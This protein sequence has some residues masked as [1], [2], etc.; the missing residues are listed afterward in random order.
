M[1]KILTIALLIHSIAFADEVR[2]FTDS[3]GRSITATILEHDLSSGKIRIQ[4]VGKKAMWVKPSV[5]SPEDQIYIENWIRDQRFMS[6]LLFQIKV[7][8]HKSGWESCGDERGNRREKSSSF[9]FVFNNRNSEPINGLRLEY[10]LFRDRN[11][12][13]DK[14]IES[15]I[16]ELDTANFAPNSET[17]VRAKV[18]HLSFKASGF[19][20]EVAGLTLR[21]YQE[22]SEG[23][24]LMR[25]VTYPEKLSPKK[26]LWGNTEK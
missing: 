9:T 20:N 12:N 13:G 23:K 6:D 25:E 10:C 11:R 1:R 18:G 3:Q 16:Y 14:Y 15:K 8:E 2:K 7:E 5:F 21:V 24:V 4:R 19:L 22:N 17:K 26:Y